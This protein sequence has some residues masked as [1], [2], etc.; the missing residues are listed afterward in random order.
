MKLGNAHKLELETEWEEKF[1]FDDR[2][3]TAK[4]LVEILFGQ[5]PTFFNSSDDLRTQWENPKT[6]QSLLEQLER[7][8]FAEDKL[9]MIR[10]VI[11]VD[12]HDLL[13]CDLYD[14]LEYLAY[15]TTP[16]ER[17]KRVEIVKK[18]YVLKQKLQNQQFLIMIL[19]YYERNGFKELAS[20]NLKTFIDLKFHSM[21]DA[22]KYLNMKPAEIRQ[23]YYELQHEIYS[24]KI[25]K[26]APVVPYTFDLESK[27]RMVADEG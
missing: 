19:D 22:V 26:Q 15:S 16:I 27:G 7:E 21:P 18:D 12:G 8:G 2:L 14:V 17:A 25:A 4:E 9:E 6:R 10:R 23:A 11:K 13:K 3:V 20:E 5:L 24:V 1:Q